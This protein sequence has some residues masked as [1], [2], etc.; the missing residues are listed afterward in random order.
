MGCNIFDI[1]VFWEVARAICPDHKAHEW[2]EIDEDGN[3]C[4]SF[5][6]FVNWAR[7][8][9][10]D[11]PIGIVSTIAGYLTEAP[12]GWVVG[13]GKGYWLEGRG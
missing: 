10:V 3:G 11:L 1:S 9:G 4:V 8:Q 5:P 7:G 12:G 13:G 6:E 2:H